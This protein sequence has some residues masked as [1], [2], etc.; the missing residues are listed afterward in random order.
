MPPMH[1]IQSTFAGGEFAPSLYARVDIQKYAS[2]LRTARN[3]FIH[4]H[5]GASNRPGTKYVAEVK[6]SAKKTRLIPFEFST[7]QA[8]VIEAGE[9]YFRFFKDRGAI[10]ATA[11]NGVPAYNSGTTYD[12]GD[13][14][15]S[16]SVAYKCI[17]SGTGQ[18]PASSPTY[19]TA[20][21]IYEVVSPYS[22]D[23][24]AELK[25]TQS[26]D[27]L[28]LFHPDYPIKKLTRTD[29][30]AWTLEDLDFKNGPF[31][32]SNT[33]ATTLAASATTGSSKTLTASAA[34]F[35]TS[36][37]SKH[38]GALFRLIH[39]IPA[40]SVVHDFNATGQS[41]SIKNGGTW[42]VMSHG[43]WTGTVKIEKSTAV[44]ASGNPIW[45]ELRSFSSKDNF[46]I[47]TYGEDEEYCLLRLNC[48]AFTGGT[49]SAW[50]SG[51]TY[52]AD[53]W[54]TY[55]GVDYRC[56]VAESVGNQPDISPGFWQA[57][58][59][60][61]E[62]SSDPF[63]QTGIVKVTAVAS[64]TSA[65]IDILTEVGD[66]TAITDWAEGSW[67]Y[68][69]GFPRC[70]LFYQ[71]RFTAAS[72][73]SEPQTIWFSQTANYEDFG[74]STPLVDS[75]GISI[76]LPSR[77]MNGINNLVA[78]GEIIALTSSSEWSISPG[79]TGVL[80]PTSIQTKLE[81]SRGCSTVDPASISNRIVF[82]QPMGTVAC[83]MG[84]EYSSSGYASAELSIISNH[85]FEGYK[86]VEMAYQQ[87]PDSLIWAVR[88]DGALLSCTYMREQEVLAWTH[89]DTGEV[90]DAS[91]NTTFDSFESICSI[92][93]DDY[94]EIWVVV[95]RGSTRFV[96][97][98][99]QRMASFDVEDQYFMD[100]GYTYTGTAAEYISGLSWLEGKEVSILADGS[101]DRQVVQ[102]ATA[103]DDT[104][105]Y[106]IDDYV[107]SS[108]TN[109][110]CIL[111]NTN[112]PP[113]SSPTCW[114]ASTPFIHVSPAASVISLGLPYTADLETLNVEINLNDGTIQDRIVQVG[115]VTV[116][117]LKSRGGWVGSD[118]EH[119]DQ[120]IQR[121][122]ENY[123][124]PIALYT[125]DLDITIDGD[126][127]SNG[128]VFIRQTDP[129]PM[130]I[131]AVMPQVIT[132]E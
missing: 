44:D 29:H 14:V 79:S 50:A 100:C 111:P 53:Q 52:T 32:L 6:T 102:S 95:K 130:T 9:G 122:N 11:A 46:N 128:R 37:T 103:W 4:P 93:G 24:L 82:I 69:R 2:G 115:K 12:V 61:V 57:K 94:D 117:Y 54:V 10:L 108:G 109:Y 84:Y 65:T 7:E 131:L 58:T 83:D 27:V 76:N 5:G 132:G 22:E 74:R 15:I 71:D 21:P 96:E 81:G 73:V 85:L 8:Y 129:L 45:T 98:F 101:V 127:Q 23:D 97:Y 33:T 55:G 114:T 62:L 68:Y 110:R 80:S 31:M 72:T 113:A 19:W 64:S 112:Q 16:S 36:A 34:L 49:G 60:R 123:G 91:G 39:Q 99:V 78:L 118:S 87:E 26:A 89:H 20:T 30:A 43:T 35:D 3:M 42:R 77:K 90:T 92:P 40:Q 13:F 75:D 119:L 59:C 47:N 126:F 105:E 25:Y 51:T 106:E 86:I 66:T 120:L 121:S 1:H 67:S 124:D 56:T 18:T 107:S 70:G 125:G 38:I 116:R 48:T 104:T 17:Q 41:T 28:Y 88:S 63:E